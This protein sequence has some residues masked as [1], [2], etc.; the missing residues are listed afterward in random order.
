MKTC[1]SSV[2]AATFSV[3]TSL[4][5]AAHD[6]DTL[7][8]YGFKDGAAD[9][10][11][12]GVPIANDAGDSH[13]GT[14]FLNGS[15]EASVTFSADAPG[16]YLFDSATYCATPLCEGI[17]SVLFAG[18]SSKTGD[19]QVSF[20]GLGSAISSNDDFTIE[21]FF[22]TGEDGTHANSWTPML[23]TECGILYNP[24]ATTVPEDESKYA[25]TPQSFQ[26]L[27][28]GA[29]DQN[30][31]TYVR[32]AT[33]H[34][35]LMQ[36][37]YASWPY[38]KTGQTFGDGMWHHYAVTY[39][40]S[41]KKYA[42]T[43]DY[44]LATGSCSASEKT[45]LDTV[46]H[47][48]LG[49]GGFKGK[50]AGL[51]VSK[52]VRDV[53]EFLRCSNAPTYY[54]E[55]V[56][57]LSMDGENGQSVT[58]VE[59]NDKTV[60]FA[61]QY[62]WR[63]APTGRAT[64]YTWTDSDGNIVRPAY[65][66]E[67]PRRRRYIVCSGDQDLCSSTGAVRFI[68]KTHTDE[69]WGVTGTGLVVSNTDHFVVDS[70]SFTMETWFKFDHETWEHKLVDAGVNPSLRRLTLFG[71]YNSGYHFDFSCF[72]QYQSDGYRMQM[73]AYQPDNVMSNAVYAPAHSFMMDHTWHHVAVVYDDSTYAFTAYV[74]GSSVASFRLSVPFRPRTTSTSAYRRY[75]IGCELNNCAF[76]GL[77]DEVRLV[78]RAL[79]PDEFLKFRSDQGLLLLFR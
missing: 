33:Y 14:L 21:F 41:Q 62:A 63:E 15:P 34:K 3:A 61:G 71:L 70:G 40:T 76:E 43:L 10:S 55:T 60:P 18:G 30:L 28:V 7:A 77:M 49:N 20:D 5:F 69:Q 37:T 36:A 25:G 23:Q 73:S 74:D 42:I 26:I 51:R 13:P 66:N 4:A 65:T 54:P 79:S 44:G 35:A 57:H 29:T 39:A 78:R 38:S 24:I 6:A 45:V 68:S 50:I 46:K 64:A 22:K 59:N 2:F 31:Y 67:I 48:F 1:V 56:F 16:R 9:T 52:K 32:S 72:L 8:F 19:Q 47:L 58:T 75:M 53:A 12:A 11:L 17:Q 27:L